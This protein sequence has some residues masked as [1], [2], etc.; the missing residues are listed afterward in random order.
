M[1]QLIILNENDE[2]RE[3]DIKDVDIVL[4]KAFQNLED[5]STIES[6]YTLNVNL[7]LQNIIMK[8]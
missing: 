1:I 3:L 2:W 7:P 4:H 5:P 8:S 6:A